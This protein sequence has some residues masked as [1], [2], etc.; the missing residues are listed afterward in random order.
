[1]EKEIRKNYL[2][3][4]QKYLMNSIDN[5]FIILPKHISH[6]SVRFNC[7]SA[8]FVKFYVYE[9]SFGMTQIGATCFGKSESLQLDSNEEKDSEIITRS[10]K[11]Q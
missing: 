1:M 11:L 6:D 4:K 2:G 9:D 3:D 7:D 10:L 5:S 8:G